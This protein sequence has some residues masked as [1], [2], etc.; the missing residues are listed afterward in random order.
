MYGTEADFQALIR[1]IRRERQVDLSLYK[2]SFVQ[3]RLAAR[4]RARGVT[5]YRAYMRLL[6]EEEYGNLFDTLTINYTSF[7]R[8]ASTFQALRDGVLR[9]LIREKERHGIRRL[10]IW[11]AGCASGEEAYSLAILVTQILGSHIHHW[12]V[13]ILGTDI[14]DAKLALAREGVYAPASFR[15]VAWPHIERYFI[16]DGERRRVRPELKKLVRF[17]RHDLLHNDPPRRFDVILCR[18]VL[19]YF[20]R[21][22]QNRIL[23]NF[24]KALYPGGYLVLG[25]TEILP[26]DFAPYFEVVNRRE[27]IYRKRTNTASTK[28]EDL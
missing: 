6:D 18:N 4:L 21:H 16:R 2:P 12:G 19:I 15:G 10:H 13:H 8:D 9:P 17:Q 25:K 23:Q 7:F 24:H 28:K 14:D 27:H 5:T 22:R 26:L 1:K 11:S 3:R 20:Q